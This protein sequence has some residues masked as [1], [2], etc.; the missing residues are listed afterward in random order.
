MVVLILAACFGS[1]ADVLA[2][3][4]CGSH[5]TVERG[6]TLRSI[7]AACGTTAQAMRDANPGM[8]WRLHV[9]QVLDMPAESK[10]APPRYPVQMSG[11]THVVKRGDTLGG[12]AFLYG[13]SLRDLLA[14]NR[15]IWNPNLIY[16]GQ[17]INLPANALRP[18]GSFTYSPYPSYA[19]PS[20]VYV[21]PTL[22]PGYA[23]LRVTYEHGL[24][25]RTGPGLDYPEIVSPFVSAVKDTY[26]QYRK[27]SMTVGAMGLVW[28]EV[29][30]SWLVEG[31]STG[32][33]MVRDGLGKYFTDPNIGP[34]I[35]PND[36]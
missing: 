28:V 15:Q 35:D 26:W 13:I 34:R 33:I 32:W 27:D 9:G 19:H 5:V 25:V 3:S 21:A 20:T 17:V 7:A 10:P 6:D 36:P 31:Y 2:S 8:D 16:P 24:L 4:R 23:Y 1:A 14:V 29:R 12:I 30:L 22:A 11:S 18:S